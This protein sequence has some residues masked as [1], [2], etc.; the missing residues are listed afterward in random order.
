MS[1]ITGKIYSNVTVSSNIINNSNIGLNILGYASGGV[2]NFWEM[3]DTPDSYL[4]YAGNFLLVNGPE[5]GISFAR[6]V[7]IS[8]IEN[9]QT[10]LDSKANNSS[11]DLKV[12]KVIGKQLSTEDYTSAEKSKLSGI[13]SGAEVNINADWNA[14]SGDA[15]ILN[16]PDITAIARQSISETATG[17]NYNNSTGVLSLDEDHVI[18]TIS[19]YNNKVDSELGKGLSENDFTDTLKSKLDGI[20]SGAQVN[21]VNSI[22]SK[23]GNVSLS[24]LD[25]SENINLYFTNERADSRISAQKGA[26]NG[27][28]E[29]DNTGKVPIE[30]LP[31]ISGGGITYK[32]TWDASTGNYPTLAPNDGEFW[33]ISVAGTISG[34]NYA[35]GDWIIYQTVIGWD[36]VPSGSAVSSVN[37]KT[38]T[39]TLS[40]TDISEGSNKY[41][42]DIKVSANL[43]VIKG[44]SANTWGN[45]ALA[46]YA[47][48]LEVVH[49]LGDETIY[50]NKIFDDTLVVN[51]RVAIGSS[52]FDPIAPEF[53]KVDG[54]T[55]S[56]FNIISGYSDYDSYVQLNIKNFNEGQSASSDFV[57]T[58]DIGSESSNYIDFGINNSNY[59]VLD[60]NIIKALDG[61]GYVE[62]GDFALGTISENKKLKLF[63]GGS[64]EENIRAELSDSNFSIT[65]PVIAPNIVV[66]STTINGYSLANNISLTKSDIGLGNADNTSDLNKPLSIATQNEIN[67]VKSFAI[68]MAIAL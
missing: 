25:I 44:V 57:A 34:I 9:L 60:F 47:K 12:D 31:P 20:E 28:A 39:V 50:G 54:Q 26:I 64:L 4:G 19:S 46:G 56:S 43:D 58:A 65:V 62:G 42:T 68:A 38:G 24:T 53:L 22:N 13:E 16:K 59:N 29:L 51:D 15:E 40:T 18:P 32:G 27:I 66:T 36:K 61:Y 2:T 37:G 8:S 7:P 5:T 55:S 45:H 35:I 63:T 41:Y 33:V 6:T 67:K 30:Q 11:L 17:L 3:N 14:T 1:D 49:L 48:D 10:V 23:T 21:T 52:G